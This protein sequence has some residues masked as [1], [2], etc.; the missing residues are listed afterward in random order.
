MSIRR[1]P[2]RPSRP[3][4]RWTRLGTWSRDM[5]EGGVFLRVVIRT[6]SAPE[7]GAPADAS[8]DQVPGHGP[9]GPA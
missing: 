4:S 1:L 7:A 5:S 2:A 9:G 6:S 3:R 8:P